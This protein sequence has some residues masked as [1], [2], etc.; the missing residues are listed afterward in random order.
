MRR[1]A[2]TLPVLVM[3][4][5]VDVV[6]V[7]VA[8]QLACDDPVAQGSDLLLVKREGVFQP[9]PLRGFQGG[10]FEGLDNLVPRGGKAR[11]FLPALAELIGVQGIF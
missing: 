10:R 3:G 6:G 11:E 9:L 4:R 1:N 8:E 2:S 5:D 7:E